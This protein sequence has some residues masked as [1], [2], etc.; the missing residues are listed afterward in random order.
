MLECLSVDAGTLSAIGSIVTAIATVVMACLTVGAFALYRLEKRREQARTG[1]IAGQLVRLHRHFQAASNL[2]EKVLADDPLMTGVGKKAAQFILD[3]NK[4]WRTVIDQLFE[5]ATVAAMEVTA[6]LQ[7][8]MVLMVRV[9]SSG[10][11][12]VSH[13]GGS[14]HLEVAAREMVD[15]LRDIT[16]GFERAYKALP[17]AS[18]RWAGGR[19][20]YHELL[21]EFTNS[22]RAR[23]TAETVKVTR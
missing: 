20:D 18:R 17:T 1:A 9:D 22:T 2:L 5:P 8:A 21:E 12:I 13:A 3:E 23:V 6:A 7:T 15:E 4:R 16:N 11:Q 14:R 10:E 19:K